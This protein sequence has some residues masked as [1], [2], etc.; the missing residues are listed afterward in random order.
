MSIIDR[1]ILALR[2]GQLKDRVVPTGHLSSLGR[3]QFRQMA[4][5]I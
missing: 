4:A 3:W 2:N 1:E 5:N